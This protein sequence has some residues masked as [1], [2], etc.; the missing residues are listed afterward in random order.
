MHMTYPISI[1]VS[2]LY[3][4]LLKYTLWITRNGYLSNH[5]WLIY[6]VLHVIWE[7]RKHMWFQNQRMNTMKYFKLLNN[8]LDK[9]DHFLL[10]KFL[11]HGYDLNEEFKEYFSLIYITFQVTNLNIYKQTIL[12]LYNRLLPWL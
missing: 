9:K 7:F 2:S 8:F 5:N 1:E 10:Y 6:E 11:K 12:H 4:L 3:F